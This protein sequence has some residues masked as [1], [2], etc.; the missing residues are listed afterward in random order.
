MPQAEIRLN[1]KV[2]SLFEPDALLP[3]QYFDTFVRKIPLEPE[4]RLMWA[5][6]QDAI[7]DFQS[8]IARQNGTPNTDGGEVEEWILERDARW[9]FSFPNI[10]EMLGIDPEYLR[11]GL[12]R[13]KEKQLTAQV[14]VKNGRAGA[15][16]RKNGVS[17]L[18][19]RAS[20]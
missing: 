9:L 11:R 17:T 15:P 10:C 14:A 2:F 3:I 7:D 12:V 8:R 20:R 1:Q 5:I 18:Q 4:K 13:W 19:F 6:L 16:K